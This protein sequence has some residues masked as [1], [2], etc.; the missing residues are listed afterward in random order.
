MAA[1][2]NSSQVASSRFVP[3]RITVALVSAIMTFGVVGAFTIAGSVFEALGG[4][5]GCAFASAVLVFGDW[6]YGE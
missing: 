4:L 5:A 3:S 6:I 1:L 2:V